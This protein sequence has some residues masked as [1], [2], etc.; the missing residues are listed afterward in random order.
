MRTGINKW[1]VAYIIGLGSVYLGPIAVN[2][3]ALQS[4]VTCSA[5]D[6]RVAKSAESICPLKVGGIIPDVEVVNPQTGKAVKLK[7]IAQRPTIV[8]FYRGGWCPYC[9]LHLKDLQEKE[10]SLQKL[11][12]QILALSP[13]Q[14]SMMKQHIAEKKFSYQLFSDAEMHAA[15]AFGVAFQLDQSQV[16]KLRSYEIDIAKASGKTHAW[17]PVP[18][19]FVV[20]NGKIEYVYSNPNYKVRLKGGDLIATLEQINKKPGNKAK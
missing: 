5:D 6:S 1:L 13:D 16:E 12:F 15:R 17:L 10:A 7:Q 8:I 2:S 20:I 18:S 4:D 3:G 14:P 19:V 9:N 11:G